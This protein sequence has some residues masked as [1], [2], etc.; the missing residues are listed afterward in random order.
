MEENENPREIYARAMSWGF[1]TQF[2]G[3]YVVLCCMVFGMKSYG[4]LP[5]FT[6]E[7]HMVIASILYLI[8]Q[9]FHLVFFT[10]M[11]REYVKGG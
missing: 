6:L 11:K 3:T 4:L 7:K 2:V 5:Y 8:L 9:G 1:V 10:Y